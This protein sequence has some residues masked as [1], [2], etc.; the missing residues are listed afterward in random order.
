MARS[1]RT[2]HKAATIS[3]AKQ[4]IDT[5][6]EL[7]CDEDPAHFDVALKKVARHKVPSGEKAKGKKTGARIDDKKT[8]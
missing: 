5:A 2:N 7:G 6:R 8:N 3:Q 4:F 1:A